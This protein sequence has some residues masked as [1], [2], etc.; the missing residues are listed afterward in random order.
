MSD[1]MGHESMASK[2][3]SCFYIQ[4]LAGFTPNRHCEE[5]QQVYT[6]RFHV[7]NFKLVVWFAGSLKDV[8]SS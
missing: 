2:S 6:G 8:V 1:L 3:S 5:R 7:V 4:G